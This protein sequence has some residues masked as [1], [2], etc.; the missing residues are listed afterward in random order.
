MRAF[1]LI[2][3]ISIS[4]SNSSHRLRPA[5]ISFADELCATAARLF[6]YVGTLALIAILGV[7]LWDQLPKIAAGG[8]A[9]E[10]GWS[11]A[12]RGFPAFALSS[13]DQVEKSETYTIL[14]HAGA[15]GKDILRWAER[16]SANSA[17]WIAEAADRICAARFEA[18]KALVCCNFF[19]QRR[20]MFGSV[21]GLTLWPA[22]AKR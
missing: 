1:W 12:D 9:P 7:H 17:E 6:A 21:A 22:V 3:P 16:P 19:T 5:L 8:A 11:V 13:L 4:Q 14:R 20:I 18:V 10:A 2:R 15:G